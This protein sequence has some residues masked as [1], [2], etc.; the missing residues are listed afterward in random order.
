MATTQDI[1]DLKAQFDERTAHLRESFGTIESDFNRLN[2]FVQNFKFASLDEHQNDVN[3]ILDAATHVQQQLNDFDTKAQSQG[4]T[5][6]MNELKEIAKLVHDSQAQLDQHIEQHAHAHGL[7]KDNLQT[8]TSTVEQSTGEHEQARSEYL[9]HVQQMHDTLAGLAE[10]VFGGAEHLDQSVRDKQ[11]NLLGK[12]SEEFHTLLDGHIQSHIPQ[13]LDQAQQTIVAN[14]QGLAQ[15]ATT[16]GDS[17]SQELQTLINDM[18]EFAKS[19]VHDKIEQRFSKV[20]QEAVASLMQHITEAI[21]TTTVGVGITGAMA[22][23]LPEAIAVNVALDAIRP[24]IKAF[25]ALEDIF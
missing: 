23:I 2:E 5:P 22:P 13:G 3:K 9:A 10:K 25:K 6:F 8:M 11:A 21:A 24:A 14:I 12:A 7:L 16:S 18:I 4:F 19:E 1:H 15:H 17:A 20:E